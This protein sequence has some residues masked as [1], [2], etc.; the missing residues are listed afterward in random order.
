MPV[1]FEFHADTSG[2]SVLTYWAWTP[3]SSFDLS[4][5]GSAAVLGPGDGTAPVNIAMEGIARI[6]AE[7]RAAEYEEM[8]SS[9]PLGRQIRSSSQQD[10]SIMQ[11]YSACQTLL[12]DPRGHQRHR[13]E[14]LHAGLR[15]R[16]RLPFAIA[17][18]ASGATR[19]WRSIA[20]GRY[21]S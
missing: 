11:P 18:P 8:E 6:T 10:T 16:E 7:L 3:G 19:A 9:V 13:Q 2:S 21:T 12:Y 4:N 20:R 17:R 1:G 14:Q 15:H 5:L